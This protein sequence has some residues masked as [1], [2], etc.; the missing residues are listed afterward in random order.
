MTNPNISKNIPKPV[1]LLSDVAYTT[2]RRKII[3]QELEPGRVLDEKSLARSLALGR[4]PIH[5]A[6]QRLAREGFVRVFPRRGVFVA[7]MSLDTLRQVFE[8]RSPCEEQVARCAALRADAAD[9]ERMRVSLAPVDQL[10]DEKR[11]RELVEADEQFHLALADAGKTPVLRGILVPLYG[12]SI[13]FWYWTLPHRPPD[14]IKH[15][16]ALHADVMKAVEMHDPDKAAHAI[17]TAIGGFPDRVAHMLRG[18][19]RWSRLGGARG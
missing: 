8:A 3:F 5:E 1:E 16:M 14:D 10:I 12:L 15:E 19:S 11:F 4:T 6:I 7:E 9:M 17:L 2:I 18:A 13:R